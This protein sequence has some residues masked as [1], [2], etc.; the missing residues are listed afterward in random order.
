L[1]YAKLLS[2]DVTAVH[3][4]LDQDETEKV[5]KKWK[6]W[7]EGT[8]LIV[9]DSPYRLFVEPLLEYI[10]D[11]VDHRQPNE[12]IT[13]VVPEFIPS[14]RWHNALHMRTADVLRQELLSRHGVVVT[15]V[16]YHVHKEE[17]E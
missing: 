4:S 16:P 17:K 12:T 6:T 8:R 11:I 9:L 15:D 1:R 3:I 13:V 2:N 7:G 5:Q 10:E 14:K